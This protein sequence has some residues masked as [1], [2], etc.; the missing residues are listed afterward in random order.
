MKTDKFFMFHIGILIFGVTFFLGSL[1]KQW[2]LFY[3]SSLVFA[4]LFVSGVLLEIKEMNLRVGR[5]LSFI[6]EDLGQSFALSFSNEAKMR[7][8][9][10]FLGKEQCF[11]T[12]MTI[13]IDEETKNPGM[14]SPGFENMQ[15]LIYNKI[16]EKLDEDNF[17][18]LPLGYHLIGICCAVQKKLAKE[19]RFLINL[20]ETVR[21]EVEAKLR[22]RS[23]SASEGVI[24]T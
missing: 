7:N 19:P 9:I 17:L 16:G 24:V 21:K 23:P 12:F 4:I 2:W 14:A 5:M 3:M 20:A 1:S 8:M 11:D 22:I 6:K 13:R 10:N 15:R 18:L